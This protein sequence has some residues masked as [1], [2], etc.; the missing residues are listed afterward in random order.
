MSSNETGIIWFKSKEWFKS[1]NTYNFTLPSKYLTNRLGLATHLKLSCRVVMELSRM[2]LVRWLS[3]ALFSLSEIMEMFSPLSL[4]GGD[5]SA[6][7]ILR[8]ASC[9]SI[10]PSRRSKVAKKRF[11]PNKPTC[12]RKFFLQIS[13]ALHTLRIQANKLWKDC[14][15]N[16]HFYIKATEEDLFLKNL[17]YPTNSSPQVIL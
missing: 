17:K 8:I 13:P 9:S 6:S 12:I 3:D 1:G 2:S 16:V 4:S 5:L 10:G 11:W 7:T 14:K 15:R